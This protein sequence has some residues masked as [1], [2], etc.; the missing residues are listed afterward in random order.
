VCHAAKVLPRHTRYNRKR[1]TSYIA[2]NASRRSWGGRALC[3]HERDPC[4][5]PGSRRCLSPSE[6]PVPENAVACGSGLNAPSK[7]GG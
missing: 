1:S 6:S 3:G 7:L 4:P 2:A 5:S